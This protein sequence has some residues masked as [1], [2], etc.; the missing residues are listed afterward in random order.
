MLSEEN[1]PLNHEHSSSHGIQERLTKREKKMIKN[2]PDTKLKAV[3]KKK[4]SGRSHRNTATKEEKS[5]E[6][7]LV[8]VPITDSKSGVENKISG[9]VEDK[10]SKAHTKLNKKDSFKNSVKNIVEQD[11]VKSQSI[12]NAAEHDKSTYP[13]RENGNLYNLDLMKGVLS[14]LD[15]GKKKV[16]NN[17][18][19]NV[20]ELCETTTIY[21][22]TCPT[23]V[24]TTEA[25]TTCMTTKHN[26]PHMKTTCCK[27]TVMSNVQTEETTEV[28]VTLPAIPKI[29]S[30]SMDQWGLH[31]V[32]IEPSVRKL[33]QTDGEFKSFGDIGT[34]SEGGEDNRTWLAGQEALDFLEKVRDN[35][36]QP[37]IIQHE[38]I[39]K[40]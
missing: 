30:L 24:T 14:S 10:K 15:D 33:S 39:V 2:E 25:P 26:K 28:H 40:R 18:S 6:K 34:F 8:S 1:L 35:A 36:T 27:T 7:H 9:Y 37:P 13:V 12:L 3:I 4:T 32:S 23:F 20:D 22:K 17:N 21:D 19:Y 31:V 29:D 16:S 11:A 38:E 5:A